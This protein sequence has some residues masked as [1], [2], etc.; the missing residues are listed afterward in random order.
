MGVIDLMLSQTPFSGDQNTRVHEYRLTQTGFTDDQ[1]A[2]WL[3]TP[4]AQ[5]SGQVERPTG[6]LLTELPAGEK[7]I[8]EEYADRPLTRY[9]YESITDADPEY[10]RIRAVYELPNAGKGSKIGPDVPVGEGSITVS[11]EATPQVSRIMYARSTVRSYVAFGV[12]EAP[13]QEGAINV[14]SDGVVKG[15]QVP[16]SNTQITMQFTQD[17]AWFTQNNANKLLELTRAASI[18]Y[19]NDKKMT[20]AG[21]PYQPGEVRIQGVSGTINTEGQST[22]DVNFGIIENETFNAQSILADVE[23]DGWDY[24]WIY[25]VKSSEAGAIKAKAIAGYVVRLFPRRDLN[26][27][28]A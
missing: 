15:I 28:L 25:R 12:S 27:L 1:V 9:E 20:L 6:E 22:L 4:N 5:F 8:L 10:Y 11:V 19:V 7:P 2:D 16:E 14:D 23:K 26:Q 17:N 24:F 3:S 18:G 13:D 21:L